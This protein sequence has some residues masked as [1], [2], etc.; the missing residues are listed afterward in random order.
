MFTNQVGMTTMLNMYFVTFTSEQT[1]SL[2]LTIALI[3]VL[4]HLLNVYGIMGKM[5]DA[6]E[7]MLRSA[8]ATILIAPAIIGTLLVTGG[9]L[10]SCPV[11][12]SL[13]DRLEL[14]NEKRASANLIFRHALYFIFPFSPPS[15]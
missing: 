13:G 14:S 4:G 12:G 5:I 2:G 11:V 9:A 3:S 6:L 7:G 10:M 15:Y 1:I 8:K